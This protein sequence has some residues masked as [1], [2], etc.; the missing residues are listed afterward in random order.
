MREGVAL[1]SV[2]LDERGGGVQTARWSGSGGVGCDS[3]R[4]TVI[5]G[6]G[7]ESTLSIFKALHTIKL[8][9]QTVS[10][11]GTVRELQ[12]ERALCLSR[13]RGRNVKWVTQK[14]A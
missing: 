4:L 14:F 2:R 7:G 9:L 11:N 6:G 3:A 13:F 5:G 10:V 12:A 1:G 8:S